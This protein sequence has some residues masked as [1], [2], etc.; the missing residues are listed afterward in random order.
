MRDIPKKVSRV[1]RLERATAGKGGGEVPPNDAGAGM[2]GESGK[3]ALLEA[4]DTEG[5]GGGVGNDSGGIAGE[6]A[7]GLTGGVQLAE[8]EGAVSGVQLRGQAFVVGEIVTAGETAGEISILVTVRADVPKIKA[9][10]SNELG[11]EVLKQV[12]FSNT[13][14]VP[15]EQ[16]VE[17]GLP[18][19][20][21]GVEAGGGAGGA[22]SGAGAGLGAE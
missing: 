11:A 13:K 19:A 8:I 15:Q 18:K 6:G 5:V 17:L 3:K 7:D 12:H 14:G 20:L 16:S 1:E 2:G 21:A 4:N 10:L 22:G 9:A